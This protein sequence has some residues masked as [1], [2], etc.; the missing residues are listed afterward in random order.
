[1]LFCM[2]A[3]EYAVLRNKAID[4]ILQMREKLNQGEQPTLT[5][6]KRMPAINFEAEDWST[7]VDLKSITGYFEPPFTQ[8]IDSEDLRNALDT[9]SP[10]QFPTLPAHSQSVERAVKL[11]SEASAH[12][13]GTEGRHRHI[14]VRLKSRKARPSFGSKGSYSETY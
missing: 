2:I 14:L 11:V 10:L 12:V 3:S 6:K 4:M 1:M 13:Y 8:D 9:D 5:G 7:L